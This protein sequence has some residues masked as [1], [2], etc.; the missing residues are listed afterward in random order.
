MERVLHCM[1]YQ[2]KKKILDTARQFKINLS[3]TMDED[4][5]Y[6]QLYKSLNDYSTIKNDKE[7][8]KK[9][10]IQVPTKLFFYSISN[11]HSFFTKRSYGPGESSFP[12]MPEMIRYIYVVGYA[13]LYRPLLIILVLSSFFILWKKKLLT[14]L[15]SSSLLITTRKSLKRRYSGIC[16]LSTLISL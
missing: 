12:Y 8:A 14:L 15:I 5:V 16:L 7:F 1:N 13:L 10:L 6:I 2:N 9:V 4:P 11:W 3:Y